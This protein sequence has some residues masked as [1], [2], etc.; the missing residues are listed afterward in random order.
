VWVRDLPG[1]L[2]A[3]VACTRRP[4]RLRIVRATA[5]DGALATVEETDVG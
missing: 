5:A 4:E 2:P 1:G 3:A